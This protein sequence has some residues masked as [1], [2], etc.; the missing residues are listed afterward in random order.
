MC[1]TPFSSARFDLAEPKLIAY[2]N[3]GQL[4][5][6]FTGHSLASHSPALLADGPRSRD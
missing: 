3:K 4:R 6:A 5:V 1:R 2:P